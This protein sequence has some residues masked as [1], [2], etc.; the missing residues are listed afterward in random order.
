MPGKY[1]IRRVRALN[2]RKSRRIRL[3]G[4]AGGLVAILVTLMPAHDWAQQVDTQLWGNL[5][6]D[7][8]KSQQISLGVAI[9]PKV[10]VSKPPED[11][12][13]ATLG[14]TP[15]IEYSRG[16]WVDLVGEVG[17]SRTRQT[18]K[19]NSTEIT[20]S[21]GL[22]FHVLSNLA[23]DF[24]KERLPKRRLVLRNLIRLEWRSFSYSDDTP[25][26]SSLR[27]RNRF[28]ALYPLN[29]PRVTDNGAVYALADVEFFSTADD[30]EERFASKQR[31]RIGGGYRHNYPWRFEA[32]YIWDR[33]RHAAVEAFVKGDQA[34]DIRLRRVW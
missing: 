2:P 32:L 3:H 7:W 17:V 8:I 14:V 12:G 31:L 26:S 24:L 18:D 9:E 4:A 28:E 22:R 30:L 11:P 6:I 10:L 29:R 15:S 25:D 23:N 1:R 34:V 21:I 20:P 33:S 19:V 27:L 5:T 16:T 13:W